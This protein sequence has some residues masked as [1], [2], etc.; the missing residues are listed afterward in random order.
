MLCKKVEPEKGNFDRNKY[1]CI[2]ISTMYLGRFG[3]SHE[4]LLTN[5]FNLPNRLANCT[6]NQPDSYFNKK[7]KNLTGNRTLHVLF[8]LVTII[9]VFII[10][11]F[12]V[13]IE[14]AA[15]SSVMILLGAWSNS[16]IG[17]YLNN[18]NNDK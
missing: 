13:N 18:N 15:V 11:Y 16:L 9:I 1:G 8:F 7:Y 12:S 4:Q 2:I 17:N 10:L 14:W 3:L 5:I 6:I